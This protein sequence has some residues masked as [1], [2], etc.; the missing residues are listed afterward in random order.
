MGFPGLIFDENTHR[1]VWGTKV[2]CTNMHP[3]CQRVCVWPCF[4]HRGARGHMGGHSGE[5][6]W[7]PSQSVSDTGR[8]RVFDPHGPLMSEECRGAVS[9]IC[10][11]LC[12]NAAGRTCLFVSDTLSAS[13]ASLRSHYLTFLCAAR[14]SLHVP[15]RCSELLCLARVNKI[16]LWDLKY[17]SRGIK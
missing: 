7:A 10:G 6:S 11:C 14:L 16:T 15:D 8:K 12:V 17:C 13:A 1:S 4:L 9:Y 2:T 5:P 3:H